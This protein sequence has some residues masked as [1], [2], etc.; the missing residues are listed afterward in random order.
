MCN[1][2]ICTLNTLYYN[3]KNMLRLSRLSRF[4]YYLVCAPIGLFYNTS[5]CDNNDDILY[6]DNDD[7]FYDKYVCEDHTKCFINKY[8]NYDKYNIKYL[9]IYLFIMKI[10]IFD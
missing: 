4:K 9:C 8:S 5:Y 10:F 1:Y 7:E 3:Y 6:M 2:I